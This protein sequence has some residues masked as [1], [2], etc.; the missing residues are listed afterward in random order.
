[1]RN[2]YRSLAVVGPRGTGTF[3]RPQPGDG[4]AVRGRP[5]LAPRQ[6]AH[7]TAVARSDYGGTRGGGCRGAHRRARTRPRHR[8]YGASAPGG[9]RA[10]RLGGLACPLWP[11]AARAGRNA[12][13]PL[14]PRSLVVPDG[15]R[16][17]RG[18]DAD[19]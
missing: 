6:P 1:E 13:R 15:E 9:A 5:R 3:S 2:V 16:A 7:R 17:W 18:L 19:P 4:L 10:H 12:D 8:P 14:G 11:S